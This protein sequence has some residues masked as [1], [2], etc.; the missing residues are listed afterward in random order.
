M[1]VCGITKST[2]MWCKLTSSNVACH[3]LVR[4]TSPTSLHMENSLC[5]IVFHRQSQLSR[6][7]CFS[8]A[9]S[10]SSWVKSHWWQIDGIM[11]V[12]MVDFSGLFWWGTDPLYLWPW[13]SPSSLT[14]PVFDFPLWLYC[15]MSS[16][17]SAGHGYTQLAPVYFLTE[18]EV[19]FGRKCAQLFFLYQPLKFE[20]LERS[21]LLWLNNVAIFT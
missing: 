16:S 20:Y 13:R 5:C 4:Q 6:S 21:Q 17:S 1:Y 14:F 19:W 8:L 10:L 11:M 12:Y 18:E 2:Q 3:G 15:L 7:L 9:H